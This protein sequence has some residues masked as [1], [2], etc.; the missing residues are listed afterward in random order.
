MAKLGQHFLTDKNALKKISALLD[1]SAK[2]GSASGGKD[3]DTVIEIGPGHG[4]LTDELRIM[5]NELRII[6]IEKDGQLVEVLQKKFSGDKNIEVICG[7]A[8][9]LLSSIIHNSSFA[10]HNYKLTGNIPYYITGKLLRTISELQEKPE[11]SVFT[12]QKEVAERI[13]AQP[14][15]MNPVRGRAPLGARSTRPLARA[16]SNGMNRLAASVQFWAEPKI[17]FIIPRDSFRPI[18]EVDSATIVLKKTVPREVKTDS[19]YKA[20]RSIFAQPRKTVLNNISDGMGISKKETIEK[21]GGVGIETNL[22]PQNL[23][24]EDIIKI[25]SV[26]YTQG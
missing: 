1:L 10:I 11:V 24:V 13:C 18:P 4:E 23:S 20:V 21:L 3:G 17:A 9:K 14:K 7:D 8:L 22:R 2:G 15:R 19:Y 26:F 6:A 25:A 12:I 16:A 5:N